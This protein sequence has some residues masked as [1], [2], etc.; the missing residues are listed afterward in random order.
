MD[1]CRKEKPSLWGLR[2]RLRSVK[3]ALRWSGVAS[4]E[5]TRRWWCPDLGSLRLVQALNLEVLEEFED[6]VVLVEV[7]VH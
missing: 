6:R 2:P 1:M 7:I 3:E 4:W 5:V